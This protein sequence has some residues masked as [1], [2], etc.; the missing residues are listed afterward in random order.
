MAQG[1]RLRDQKLSKLIEACAV[2]MTK[3]F[4]LKSDLVECSLHSKT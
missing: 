3:L 4:A 2:I 1:N